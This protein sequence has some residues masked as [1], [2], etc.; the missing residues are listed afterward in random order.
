MVDG[1]SIDRGDM[2]DEAVGI[3]QRMLLKKNPGDVVTFTVLDTKDKPAHEVKMTLAPYPK[4]EITAERYYTDE[5]GFGVREMVPLDRYRLK[6]K[7]DEKDGVLVDDPQ[8][9]RFGRQRRAS[10]QRHDHQDQRRAGHQPG[11]LQDH[12]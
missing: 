1:K 4:R 5:I 10:P 6:L 3:L 8:A 12:L 11:S 9:G 2:P 7:K